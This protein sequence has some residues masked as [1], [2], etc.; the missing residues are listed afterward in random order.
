MEGFFC[1]G[2]QAR[3]DD[4]L[5]PN[6][7]RYQLRHTSIPFSRTAKIRN[8]LKSL[9]TY[10]D[11]FCFGEKFQGVHSAF[12]PYPTLFHASEWRSEIAN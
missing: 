8:F 10:A 6:Q 12:A 5:V 11:I 2:G 3:T 9:Q 4:P 7:V 1:R